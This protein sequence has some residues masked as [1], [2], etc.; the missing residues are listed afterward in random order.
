MSLKTAYEEG[1][2][3]IFDP[4]FGLGE[5]ITIAGQPVPALVAYGRDINDSNTVIDVL[6]LTVRLE[7]MPTPPAYRVLAI[8]DGT[9]WYYW[10]QTIPNSRIDANQITQDGLT[11]TL[12]FRR[13]ERPQPR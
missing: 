4:D 6:D 1:L 2:A 10:K 9:Q 5:M 13:N 8:V 3:E 11:M 12:R 7:D